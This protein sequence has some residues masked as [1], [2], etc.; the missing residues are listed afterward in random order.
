MKNTNIDEVNH[1][2][3][4]FFGRMLKYRREA[5]H[6]TQDQAAEKLH[7]GL[8]TYKN[9][10]TG[11]KKTTIDNFYSFLTFYNL[12]ADSVMFPSADDI[13]NSTLNQIIRLLTRSSESDLELYLAI[14]TGVLTAKDKI[15]SNLKEESIC[16]SYQRAFSEV[17]D[18]HKSSR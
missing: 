11:V 10:E 5:L 16:E 14:L 6:L 8:S 3:S 9:I 18:K 2:D 4:R 1:L 13:N 17:M 15:P 7:I 12:S